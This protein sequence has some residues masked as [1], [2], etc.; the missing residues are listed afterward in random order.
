M[1][2]RFFIIS[3]CVSLFAVLTAH[4]QEVEKRIAGPITITSGTLTND[5]QHHTALFEKNV[6]AKTTDMTIYAD[7][8]LVYYK[9]QGG[10]V[11]RIDATGNVKVY[12]GTRLITSEAAVYYADED[13]VV[14]TGD[15]RAVD[16]DNVVT[17][18]VMTYYVKD[19][20][21][22]VEHSKVILKSKSGK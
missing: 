6:V 19:D 2:K 10:D 7:R 1:L 22:V 5:S 18:S 14:F 17:G 13:K 3:I 12:K 8:M 4:A 11:T 15:P 9:E 20:R 16:G 21:S